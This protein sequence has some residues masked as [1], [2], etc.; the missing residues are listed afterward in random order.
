MSE[1]SSATIWLFMAIWTNGHSP[2]DYK[3][4]SKIGPFQTYEQCWGAGVLLANEIQSKD[5]VSNALGA[6]ERKWNPDFVDFK[7]MWDMVCAF[8]G[9]ADLC[10]LKGDPFA[11]LKK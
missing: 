2:L 6:C 5:D 10:W 3:L 11:E 4:V 8:R 1:G 9:K 7:S